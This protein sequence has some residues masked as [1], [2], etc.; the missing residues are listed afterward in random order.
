MAVMNSASGTTDETIHRTLKLVF[1]VVPI[2]AGLDKF[3]NLLVQWDKYL[4]PPIAH[5]LP[6]TPRFFM[7]LVGIIEIVAGLGVLLTTW[8]RVFALIVGLWLLG[9][10]LNLVIGGYYDIAVRDIVMAISAFCLARLSA[11]SVTRQTYV[12]PGTAA[13]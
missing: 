8:T 4:A 6:M 7:Y 3:S 12:A 10:A 11:S 9:I 2:V 1:G 13:P 5:L